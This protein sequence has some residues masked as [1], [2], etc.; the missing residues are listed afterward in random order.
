MWSRKA[1]KNTS[2]SNGK[3]INTSSL[4]GEKTKHIGMKL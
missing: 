2:S 4:G 3:V 1:K